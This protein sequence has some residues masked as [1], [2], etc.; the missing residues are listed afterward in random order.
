MRLYIIK[1][2]VLILLVTFIGSLIGEIGP[3]PEMFGSSPGAY[4]ACSISENS[5]FFSIIKIIESEKVHGIK[6]DFYMFSWRK[7]SARNRKRTPPVS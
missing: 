3:E 5:L 1:Q 4:A 7:P 2:L 6:T